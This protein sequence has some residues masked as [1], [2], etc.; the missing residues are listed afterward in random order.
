MRRPVVQR[1]DLL[2]PPSRVGGC[3]MILAKL[4]VATLAFGVAAGPAV[5]APVRQLS[6]QQRAAATQAYVRPTTDC[7][8]SSVV[9]NVRF[10]K[11]DPAANLGDLI[12]EAVPDCLGQVRAMIAAYDRYFGDGAGE[13]FFMG[14]YLDLLPNVLLRQTRSR[15]E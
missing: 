5:E 15:P 12:V 3:N 6:V 4:A 1:R 9:A 13:E 2:Y 11:E 7:I 14:P 8:A 10:R